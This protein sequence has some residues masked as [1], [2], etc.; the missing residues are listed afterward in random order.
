MLGESPPLPELTGVRAREGAT[1]GARLLR[2]VFQWLW[3]KLCW[4]MSP[5]RRFGGCL[6]AVN[7]M[8][9]AI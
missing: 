3:F 1:A 9:G 4:G 6:S 5:C 2:L 8:S 7:M